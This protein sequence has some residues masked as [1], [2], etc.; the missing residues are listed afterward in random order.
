M[1]AVSYRSPSSPPSCRP[2]PG[3]WLR[4]LCG[5]ALLPAAVGAAAPNPPLPASIRAALTQA[6]LPADSLYL[7]IAPING[8]PPRLSHQAGQLAHPASLMKLV[9][10]AA[11]LQQ[12][13]RSFQW[14]TGIHLD[15]T[16]R[17]GVLAGSIYLKGGGDPGLVPV[18]L[19]L[20]LRQVQQL[21]ID[22]IQGDI[23]LDRSAYALPV[24]DPAAF[25]GE[26]LKPYN[27][28]PDAL[29][30]NYK[31]ITLN[32]R[33]DP[34]RGVAIVTAE[35]PLSGWTPPDSVRLSDGPCNDWRAGLQADFSSPQRWR[36]TGSYP[37][38]CGER[39]WPVAY[40]DPA[41]Y[42]ARVIEAQWRALGARL[43]GRVRDGLVPAGLPETAA[44][45]SPPLAEVMRDMN[46]YSNNQ[47]AQQMLLALSPQLPATFE[48]A[49]QPVA[50]LLGAVGCDSAELRLDNGSGLSRDER[51]T[52][53]CLGRWLQ[54]SWRQPWM[55]DLLGSLPL[56]GE[57]T[58]RRAF[59]VAGRAHLKTGSLA[60]VAAIAGVVHGADGQRQAVVVILNHPLAS[61]DGARQV[62]DAALRWS[63]EEPAA[64]R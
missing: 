13:G 34:A 48:A 3:V 41:S 45:L 52:P 8:G 28:R 35:P 12:L 49:R 50:N 9:T 20:L 15:G 33:P 39:S 14:R 7:W 27:V 56:A 55:P 38:A 44:F 6:Q 25:D 30:V 1:P 16:P 62:L 32:L 46:L 5:L 40:N 51:I 42:A 57:G 47:I 17:R 36:L 18:R 53:R 4:A 61:R 58:A 22:E 54:W 60:N 37:L 10:S 2:L 63:I 21:G 29:L 11:A 24:I 26:P 59:S 64:P 23:V 31:S 19:W 43:Q